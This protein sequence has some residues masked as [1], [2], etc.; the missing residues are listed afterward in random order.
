[1]FVA[2]CGV[3]DG[4]VV[5]AFAGTVDAFAEGVLVWLAHEDCLRDAF[6]CKQVVAFIELECGI[7]YVVGADVLYFH[8]Y[9]G[10]LASFRGFWA[11]HSCELQTFFGD[12]FCLVAEHTEVER[13]CIVDD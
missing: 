13:A 9:L 10:E 7:C 4:E 3:F 2:G 6:L 11:E 12:V 1:M 8:L 5:Y